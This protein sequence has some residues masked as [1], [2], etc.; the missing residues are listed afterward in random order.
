MTEAARH[1][2]RW[3]LAS[4]LLVM[5]TSCAGGDASDGTTTEPQPDPVL[6]FY[7]YAPERPMITRAA[8]DV[9]AVSAEEYAIY[10]LQIWVFETNTNN[11]VGYLKPSVYPTDGT[12]TM[13]QM[14]VSKAFA[15]A[16]TKPH[17]DVYVIANSATIGLSALGKN[18]SR[19]DLEEAVIGSESF[20]VGAPVSN[21]VDKGLPMSGVLRDQ[22]IIGSNPVLTIGEGS[23][24]AKVR[25]LRTVSK[26]RYVFSRKIGTTDVYITGIAIDGN[27][28]PVQEYV[29][30][31]DRSYRIGSSYEPL[32]A[33][34]HKKTTE[35][36]TSADPDAYLYTDQSSQE[37][38]T[39]IDE[40]VASDKLTQMGPFYFKETDKKISGTITYR[41]GS[42]NAQTVPFY[43]TVDD[44]DKRFVRNHSW[45][46]YGYFNGAAEKPII[47]VWVD[48]NWQT[49]DYF[50]IEN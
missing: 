46:V 27:M 19:D 42:S 39:L 20:G 47:T 45:I 30:L 21:I 31:T 15:N 16:V 41:V 1:I 36:K 35:V 34:L 40:G 5:L 33:T 12:G 13:Y 24:M 48:T 9:N 37:Y 50:T 38:E 25:L 2:N 3:W 11:L 8:D 10:S 17:V 18:T 14:T 7:V 23:T 49:G 43:M 26:M 32:T 4:L 6:T 22:S 28:I 44:V 29:F